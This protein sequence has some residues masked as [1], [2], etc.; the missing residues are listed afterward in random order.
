MAK[1]KSWM[2][3]L[4]YFN[5]SLSFGITMILAILLG[6]Y[7]GGWLDRQ[8]GTSPLFLL[9]GIILGVV[10]GFYN[11]WSVLFKLIQESQVRKLEEEKQYEMLED[12]CQYGT[13]GRKPERGTGRKDDDQ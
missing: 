7:A 13:R 1:E 4:R 3:Y 12:I 9:F 5:L 10:A 8:M 2:K 6:F 11:L